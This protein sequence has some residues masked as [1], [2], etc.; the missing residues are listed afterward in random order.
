MVK[1]V[2]NLYF[3]WDDFD[4]DIAKFDTEDEAKAFVEYL[5]KVNYID[6]IYPNQDV[7]VSIEE[8]NVDG[9]DL[10]ERITRINKEIKKEKARIKA[11]EE[12]KLKMDIAALKE[13]KE[14]RDLFAPFDMQKALESWDTFK[15]IVNDLHKA[16]VESG[17]YINLFDGKIDYNYDGTTEKWSGGERITYYPIRVYVEVDEDC[18]MFF[19]PIGGKYDIDEDIA[20][21]EKKLNGK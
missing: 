18:R 17:K 16:V 15:Q 4:A 2:V 8:M 3:R 20:R 19:Y 12:Q 5:E 7:D 13:L 1:Y 11:K 9:D 21:I 10:R 6:I 14:V